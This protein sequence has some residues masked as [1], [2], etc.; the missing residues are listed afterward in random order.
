MSCILETL[1]DRLPLTYVR[2]GWV[3][4]AGGTEPRV[5]RVHAGTIVIPDVLLLWRSPRIFTFRPRPDISH[6]VIIGTDILSA[7]ILEY[8]GPDGEFTLE[9]PEG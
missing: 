7:C 2:E 4:G 6:E 9:Y 5:S 1:V 8:D 3:G